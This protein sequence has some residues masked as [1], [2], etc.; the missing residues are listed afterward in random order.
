MSLGYFLCD[1]LNQAECQR[2]SRCLIILQMRLSVVE[3]QVQPPQLQTSRRVKMYHRLGP[4]YT[5][6]NLL[7]KVS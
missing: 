7:P 2:R 3:G 4:S 6:L 5:T 1:E